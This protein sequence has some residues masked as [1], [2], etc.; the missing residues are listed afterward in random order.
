[1]AYA[2]A[3]GG[4]LVTLF[5]KLDEM[6]ELMKENFTQ[7][8]FRLGNIETILK[9]SKTQNGGQLEEAVEEELKELGNSEE[10][11]QE[12][13]AKVLKLRTEED[14]NSVVPSTSIS[15]VGGTVNQVGADETISTR[16]HPL[17]LPDV[18]VN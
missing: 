1:M 2:G 18:R 8:N 7:V 11:L 6:M 17:L 5:S 16:T 10:A 14:D 9:L 3:A 12:K 4:N 13:P 15:A